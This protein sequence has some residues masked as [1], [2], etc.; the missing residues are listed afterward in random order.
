MIGI[1]L[2]GFLARQTE[3]GASQSFS[4]Y[5]VVRA[6]ITAE[7]DSYQSPRKKRKLVKSSNPIKTSQSR[8]R[9]MFDLLNENEAPPKAKS[10]K[11]RNSKAATA[12]IKNQP[13]R[14]EARRAAEEKR[15]KPDEVFELFNG[16]ELKSKSRLGDSMAVT[17]VDADEL[18][19]RLAEKAAR[20]AEIKKWLVAE[21]TLALE[22][23]RQAEEAERQRL[24]AEAAVKQ[25]QAEEERE[26]SGSGACA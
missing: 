21:A 8:P 23:Q 9:S 22:K 14:G 26:G 17:V 13:S 12:P 4:R 11:R 20:R 2:G 16:D 6:T 10:K 18:K 24:A 1:T 5:Y 25:R 15:K 3:A 19:K 7:E